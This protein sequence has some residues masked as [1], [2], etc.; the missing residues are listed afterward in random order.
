MNDSNGGSDIK[1]FTVTVNNVDPTLTA[2][3]ASVAVDEGDTATNSGT[4]GDVPADVVSI[5]ASVG[6]VIDNGDGTWSWSFDSTD[7][8][9]ESQTVTITATDEDG[10]LS[11]AT[12][13]HHG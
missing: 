13:A 12:F 11:T 7:G 9:V 6:T 3:L 5:S 2:D 10:G 1:T 4:Y 8:P